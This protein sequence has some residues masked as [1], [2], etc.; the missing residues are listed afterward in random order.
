[1]NTGALSPRQKAIRIL[2][3]GAMR[4]GNFVEF[5]TPD[6]PLY[7][8]EPIIGKAGVLVVTRTSLDTHYYEHAKE[9]DVFAIDGLTTVSV[10]TERF[11]A[12]PVSIYAQ[13]AFRYK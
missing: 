5:T 6:G 3:V 11:E 2:A 12:V 7:T 1:M 9:Y 8:R 10:P 13:Q 4:S